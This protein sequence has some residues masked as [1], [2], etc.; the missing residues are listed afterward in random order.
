MVNVINTSIK[1]KLN[2]HHLLPKVTR[3]GKGKL[4]TLIWAEILWIWGGIKSPSW[5]FCL[6]GTHKIKEIDYLPYKKYFPTVFM[7]I[8]IQDTY[9]FLN[10][11]KPTPPITSSKKTQITGPITIFSMLDGSTPV[12]IYKKNKIIQHNEKNIYNRCALSNQVVY[13]CSTQWSK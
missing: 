12:H 11:K 3:W 5:T 10:M 2:V 7:T 6:P 13:R 1:I 4:L 8:T 9:F